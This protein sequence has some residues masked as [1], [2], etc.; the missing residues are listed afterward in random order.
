MPTCDMPDL[1][2]FAKTF[3]FLRATLDAKAQGQTV[4]PC[5]FCGG[6]VPLQTADNGHTMAACPGCGFHL[7][8]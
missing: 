6:T 4:F 5:P 3:S 7:M 8:E 1:N 2:H